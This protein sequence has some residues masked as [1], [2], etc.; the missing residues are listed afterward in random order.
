MFA[1]EV[2]IPVFPSFS[3]F[4]IYLFIFFTSFAYKVFVRCGIGAGA[5]EFRVSERL[6]GER[7]ARVRL[8]KREVWSYGYVSFAVD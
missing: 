7:R 6:E 8:C 5:V 4:L 1:G 2:W 3:V